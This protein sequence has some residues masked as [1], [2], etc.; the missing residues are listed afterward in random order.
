MSL[1]TLLKNK[2]VIFFY[3]ILFIL[4]LW[5]IISYAFD[6][7]SMIFPS[8]IDAVKSMFQLLGKKITYQYL[9]NTLLRTIVGFFV[10]F[11][12]ALILGIFGGKYENFYTFLSP[13]MNVFKSVPTVAFVYLFIIIFQPKY[14]PI[15]V[16]V[17]VSLPILYESV[18]QGIRKTDPFILEASKVDGANKLT[19]IFKIRL[20]LAIPFIAV[21]VSSSLAL[22]FKVEIMSEVLTGMTKGG[23]GA[24]LGALQGSE[25]NLVNVFGYTLI[26]ITVVILFTMFSNYLKRVFINK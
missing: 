8:P 15:Y 23:I 14:A 5:T 13:L 7:N 22:S 6:S 26:I 11:I 18:V 10:A 19:E 9:G 21:G 12:L 24:A 16:V 25:A 4:L 1:K 17:L 2:K 3:G 20:P